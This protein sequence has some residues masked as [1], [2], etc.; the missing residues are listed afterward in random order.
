[1]AT[2]PAHCE[3]PE[4]PSLFFFATVCLYLTICPCAPSAWT[5]HVWSHQI[6]F[7]QSP[8]PWPWKTWGSLSCQV[9][10][11]NVVRFLPFCYKRTSMT[12]ENPYVL[13]YRKCFFQ[14]VIFVDSAKQ[15]WAFPTDPLP[16]R[17]ELHRPKFPDRTLR[18]ALARTEVVVPVNFPS[19]VLK[20]CHLTAPIQKTKRWCQLHGNPVPVLANCNNKVFEVSKFGPGKRQEWTRTSLNSSSNSDRLSLAGMDCCYQTISSN[21]EIDSVWVIFPMSSESGCQSY[22][23][24]ILHRID[25]YHMD[26]IRYKKVRLVWRNL[27]RDSPAEQSRKQSG[28]AHSRRSPQ[29]GTAD[30]WTSTTRAILLQLGLISTLKAS[31]AH[32]GMSC[33]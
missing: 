10:A 26:K 6:S 14:H 18:P 1:M 32:E 29:P 13:R 24:T 23:T 28:A 7:T 21:N 12:L 5:S 20:Q 15:N 25:S 4:S 33:R 17:T 9:N 22:N 27:A 16:K 30:R 11:V 2:P 8:H 3:R 19:L 31:I